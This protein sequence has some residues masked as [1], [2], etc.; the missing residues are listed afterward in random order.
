MAAP[1]A[2]LAPLRLLHVDAGREW[3]G[4]QRQVFLLARGQRDR[5]GEPLVIAQ[6]DS[7]LVKRL[8][9]AG[10]AASSLRMRGD[11]D[12]G[13]ARRLR[14]HIKAWR[15]DVVHAHDARSHALAL[16]ALLGLPRIPL[17]VTR[18]VVFVPRGRLKYGRRVS[19]FIAI[20]QAVRS[21]LV[22]GGVTEDRIDV[23][24]SGVP[25][26]RPEPPRDWRVELGWPRDAVICGLV[27]AMTSEKGT[28]LLQEITHQLS[29]A[30]RS[31]CRLVLLG[32]RGAG[33]E[34]V[35]GVP[36]FRAGFVDAI[37]PAV[38]GL[39]VLW[40]PSAAEGLGTSVIDAMAL[41]VPPVAFAVGGLPELISAGTSGLLVPAGDVTA[42][43]AAASRLI[44]EPAVRSALGQAGPGQAARFG[45]DAMVDGN[46]SIYR[47]VLAAQTSGAARG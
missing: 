22:E 41:G 38:A 31:R 9:A 6:A 4:G 34:E 7:P 29:P 28:S 35:S 47:A 20:S 19:R 40:H 37:G 21:A 14:A 30:A 25:A 39:D 16:V 5:G 45:V 26:P 46:E 12:L 44:E 27:G 11:W 36:C 32:G 1:L 2:P 43:A 42:F 23:V 8:R 33:L 15:P 24:Y 17:V 3:R 10:M 13:A 18:R